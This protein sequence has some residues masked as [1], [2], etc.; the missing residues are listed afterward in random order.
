MTYHW[1]WQCPCTDR[2][3][4]TL[5]LSTTCLSY[6]AETRSRHSHT[7]YGHAWLGTGWGM[8]PRTVLLRHPLWRHAA[9]RA[10]RR[11]C[12]AGAPSSPILKHRGRVWRAG[13]TWGGHV[14]VTWWS[15]GPY[16]VSP[17]GSRFRELYYPSQQS[18][19]L[20]LNAFWFYYISAWLF[21]LCC[22]DTDIFQSDNTS[23]ISNDQNIV[24][25]WRARQFYIHA[26][27]L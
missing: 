13:V 7:S 3:P 27:Q 20:A 5:V 17:L 22:F 12:M 15:H 10:G 19:L 2:T 18:R 21:I 16:K 11:R 1:Q 25:S 26:V 24:P 6:L 4:A 8:T 23:I 14:V 9:W